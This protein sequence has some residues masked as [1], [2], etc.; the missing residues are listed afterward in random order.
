MTFTAAWMQLE[1]LIL[2]EEIQK[3]KDK[4]HMI[5]QIWNLKYGKNEPII[6]QNQTQ[7]QRT[8]LWLTK[9]KG[10]GEGCAGSQAQQMHNITFIKDN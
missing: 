3:K 6:K 2:S 4:Y 9:G 5:S 7:T 8:D 10:E 1:I